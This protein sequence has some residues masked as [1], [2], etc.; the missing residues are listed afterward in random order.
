[1]RPGSKYF[2]RNF[3]SFL[4]KILAFNSS[5]AQNSQKSDKEQIAIADTLKKVA[6]TRV[7][8]GKIEIDGILDE[9]V[10]NIANASED[11]IQNEPDEGKPATETTTVQVAYDD[12]AIYIAMVAYEKNPSEITSF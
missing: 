10:W 11:F 6:A 12:H 8:D 2:Y 1:M 7:L 4:I 5:V 3:I 9:D